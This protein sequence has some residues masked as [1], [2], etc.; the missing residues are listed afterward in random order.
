[1]EEN[2]KRD[3]KILILPNNTLR[4]PEAMLALESCKYNKLNIPEFEDNLYKCI[5]R[6]DKDIKKVYHIPD[7]LYDKYKN[8]YG[9]YYDIAPRTNM[10]EYISILGKQKFI[11][12]IMVLF[13]EC[14]GEKPIDEAFDNDYYSG[15]LEDLE[16]YIKNNEYT[17]IIMDDADLFYEMIKRKRV[18]LNSTSLILPKVGYNYDYNQNFK[19]LMPKSS[20]YEIQS[21]EFV[22]VAIITLFT[23][24][25]EVIDRLIGGNRHAK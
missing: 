16:D 23:F 22:E 13:E 12:N 1:M 7:E 25:E 8:N 20:I 21:K 11:K 10:Y 15:K 2:Y 4:V 18:N 19:K 14:L 9:Y 3:E 5:S 6:K 24:R 17:A